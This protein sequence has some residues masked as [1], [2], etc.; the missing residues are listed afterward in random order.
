MPKDSERH[1][2]RRHV[3]MAKKTKAPQA[4]TGSPVAI[5]D[6]FFPARR[7]ADAWPVVKIGSV[8]LNQGIAKSQ[9]QA[10]IAI[11]IGIM[12]AKLGDPVPLIITEDEGAGALELLHTCLS[13]VPEDSWV[14]APTG[15]IPSG[16]WSRFEGKTIISY[17]ADRTKDL[18]QAIQADIALT[19][20][21][22]STQR[23]S[24]QKPP[25]SFV[26]LTKN[27][28]T[29]LLQN[30]Y[31]TRV[32]ISADPESK[33]QRLELLKRRASPAIQSQQKIEA[34]CLRKLLSRIRPAAVEIEFVDKIINQEALNVQNVVPCYNAAMRI[35]Q[36]ITRVNNS[37]PLRP[38][39]LEAS[40]IGLDLEDL[41]SHETA[42]DREPIKTTKGDYFY[43]L[44]VFK[45]ILQVKNDFLSPRQHAIYE[46]ILKH[47]VNHK[48]RITSYKKYTDQQLLD[49]YQEGDLNKG[50]APRDYIEKSLA[51]LGFEECSYGTIHKELQVL[52]QRN[53]IDERKIPRRHN[54]SAYVATQIISEIELFPTD[55]KKIAGPGVEKGAVDVFDFLSDKTLKI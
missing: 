51:A 53:L 37:P 12:S 44:M 18:L 2:I 42:P 33:R 5:I 15:K 34:A 30:Q 27:R 10:A 17:E 26:A 19:G 29:P 4:D 25:T 16:G 55:F 28:Q 13:L 43:F 21:I 38:G 20:T 31:I 36:N 46:V 49:S 14:E 45:D 52:L 1:Q 40:F 48:R 3:D 9:L 23:K 35:L 8:L 24:E 54:K 11:I 7:G 32:H 6:H 50:W 47:N 22:A 39:E 41:A